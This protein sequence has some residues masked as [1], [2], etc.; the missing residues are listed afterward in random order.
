MTADGGVVLLQVGAA[1]G[2][3]TLVGRKAGAT[4]WQFVRITVDQSEDLL[5]EADGKVPGPPAPTALEWVASWDEA[6]RLM[7]R[8][9]WARLHPVAVHPEFVERVRVAVGERLAGEPQHRSVERERGQWERLLGR[10]ETQD[11]EGDS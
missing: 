10:A 2:S 3:V 1:G 9:P 7:D 6:L 8:Y 5:G 11:P 4:T